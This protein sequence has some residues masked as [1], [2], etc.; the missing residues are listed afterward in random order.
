MRM[1]L[2]LLVAGLLTSDER[3]WSLPANVIVD[4]SLASV[5]VEML[6]GSHT[7]QRQC[8]RLGS[9]RELRVRVSVEPEIR[10]A[11]RSDC[12]ARCVIERYQYGRIEARVRLLTLMNPER[13][14]AHELEHV[15]EYVEGV[16]YL[17]TSVQYPRRV[18]VTLPGQYETARAIAAGE[19]VASEMSRYRSR[20]PATT[21]ARRV[22]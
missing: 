7:F 1:C 22:P 12:N 10:T 4:D 21:L 20:H 17:A 13:L 18:W 14:I 8:Q 9:I 3:E 5:V 6:R 19:Q 2:A 11:A 15:R 16:N